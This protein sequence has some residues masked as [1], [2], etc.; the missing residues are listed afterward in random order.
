MCFGA[1][2]ATS[3]RDP[4]GLHPDECTVQLGIPGPWHERLPHFRMGY[5]PERGQEL[6]SE[7]MVPRQHAIAAIRAIDGLRDRVAPRLQMGEIRTIAADDLWM[8]PFY[9]Q[10]SIALHF[11]W[12]PDVPAVMRLLPTIEAELAPL[13][14]RPHWGKLYLDTDAVVPRLYPKLDAFRALADRLDP[15]GRF[16]NPFLTRLL[17]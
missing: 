9:R 7:Y 3:Q 12:Q 5:M 11:T 16:R 6:Q 2:L 17:G 8:S 4:V 13:G 10:A 1:T 14:A 15:E